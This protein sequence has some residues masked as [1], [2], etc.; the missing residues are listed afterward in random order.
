R[1]S[2]QA[3]PPSRSG[4]APRKWCASSFDPPGG[5]LALGL[6][7]DAGELHFQVRQRLLVHLALLGGPDGVVLVHELP[8]V[9]RSPRQPVRGEALGGDVPAIALARPTCLAV[10][11]VGIEEPP[12]DL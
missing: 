9:G 6:G 2:R 3:R 8:A 1:R 12:T 7:V 4:A 11:A 10:T 5:L